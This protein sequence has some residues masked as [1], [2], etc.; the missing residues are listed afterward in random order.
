MGENTNLP[1]TSCANI[2]TTGGT[3]SKVVKFDSTDSTYHLKWINWNTGK[4]PIVM[5]SINGPCPLIATMNVL[6]LREKVKLPSMLEQITANQ[7]LS[8]LGEC[9]MDCVP[10]DMKNDENAILN[11]EQ[12]IHDAME[13]LP[14]LKT[15]LDVN[16]RFTGITD[17]EYTPECIIFDILRIPL[18]HGWLKDPN[19][20][21]LQNAIGNQS[22]NQ[23]VDNIITNKTSSDPE[24][25]A[26][27]LMAE[28]FLASTASQLTQHGLKELRDQIKENEIGILF[29]NNH[30]LTLMKRGD[31]IYTLVTDHGYLTEDEII[32]ETLDN[33]EGD[34]RFFNSKFDSSS[35]F[36]SKQVPEMDA[37]KDQNLVDQVVKDYLL[38]L[39]LNEEQASPVEDVPN[40][41]ASTNNTNTIPAREDTKPVD[42]YDLAMRLQAEEVRLHPNYAPSEWEHD[43]VIPKTLPTVDQ[44]KG[45]SSQAAGPQG[46]ATSDDKNEEQKGPAQSG[47]RSDNSHLSPS[48]KLEKGADCPASGEPSSQPS[49]VDLPQTQLQTGQQA[50]SSRTPEESSSPPLPIET[51]TSEVQHTNEQPSSTFDHQEDSRPLSSSSS[52]HRP[53]S[54]RRLKSERNSKDSNCI[55]S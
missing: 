25:L 38:A 17:F 1:G 11:L 14:K 3:S 55:I 22:Y 31:D 29:R 46:S 48:D 4:I 23:L 30:F 19:L 9:L 41:S 37:T 43:W 10:E 6:L 27:V 8:Y 47:S 35:G 33:V 40:T 26:K 54:S 34:G 51:E 21:E 44:S 36:S 42:D 45:F 20:I 18:Y 39:S 49:R 13:I 5:Q 16:I 32:W 2:A 15:G 12:N 24:V 50:L 52:S 28:D 7:L 53:S